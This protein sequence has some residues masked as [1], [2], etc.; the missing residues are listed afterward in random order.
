[1]KFNSKLWMLAVAMATV[2]CQDDLENDPNNGGGVEL[3]GEKAL[4]QVVVNA[5]ITTR[6]ADP[7]PGEEGDGDEAGTIEESMV[8]DVTVFLFRN[9]GNPDDFDFK[10]TSTIYAA[11][12]VADENSMSG[13]STEHSFY[14]EV[15]ISGLYP[16]EKLVDGNPYGVIAVTNLGSTD[17]D[18]LRAELI[19]VSESDPKKTGEDLANYIQKSYGNA[20]NGF[21]MS[22]HKMKVGTDQSIVIPTYVTSTEDA[23]SVNVYVER[24]AAKIRI[25]EYEDN[26]FVYDVTNH[27]GDKVILN[28]VAIVNQLDAGEYLIKRVTEN[29]ETGED[30]P[31]LSATN[32]VYLGDEVN[33]TSALNFVI[34]PW[35][36]SKAAIADG[37]TMSVAGLTY[38]NPYVGES[39]A[40]MWNNLTEEPTQLYN[41][42]SFTTNDQLDLCY[43]MENTTSVVASQNGYSTGAVFEATYYPGSWM[44]ASTTTK[45]GTDKEKNSYEDNTSGTVTYKAADFY[46]YQNAVFKDKAA[47]FAYALA[48]V[49]PEGTTKTVYTYKDFAGND[50]A[51]DFSLADFKASVSSSATDPFGYIA[52]LNDLSNATPVA[53]IPTFNEFMN[54]GDSHLIK[55]PSSVEYH[56]GG[57]TFYPFWF[58]HANNDDN[59][60]M[61][62]MEFGIVRNNIYDLTVNG[63]KG[64]GEVEAPNPGE[65]DENNNAGISVVLY[66]KDWTLRKNDNIYL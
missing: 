62:I 39:M 49:I 50:L 45:N 42:T 14:K 25:N 17:A 13:G 23:P 6:A 16:K 66:V 46:L 63:I 15:E 33:A 7:T 22:T 57:K 58:R 20:E 44:V 38:I 47:I 34:D 55:D 30:L 4:I 3:K 53:D 19:P 8:H 40:A 48:R 37:G 11:G 31:A 52:Y 5:G 1:M 27:D 10:S 28:N 35:T 64:Y 61:G 24:L 60:V 29:A 65:P 9:D 18:K 2:G 36:R 54:S 12:Y 56:E 26:N 43:T 51:A 41:N 21:V 59:L 32:D